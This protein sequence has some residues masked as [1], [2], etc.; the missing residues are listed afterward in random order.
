VGPPEVIKKSTTLNIGKTFL[1][2]IPQV[3][4]GP[5]IATWQGL[6]TFMGKNHQLW[7]MP[8]G[9]DLQSACVTVTL[10]E[11]GTFFD[12]ESLGLVENLTNIWDGQLGPLLKI[13]KTAGDD[14][15][16]NPWL[17]IMAC[18]TPKAIARLFSEEMAGGGLASRIVWLYGDKP[19]RSVAYPS[20]QRK[21]EHIAALSERLRNGLL[22]AADYCGPFKLTD[23]AYAWGERWYEQ[24]RTRR[25][26]LAG[27]T[28][29]DF[30]VRRQTHLH[31]I[32]MVLS[33][34]R[35]KFPVIDVAEMEEA[36]SKLDLLESYAAHVFGFVGTSA[37]SRTTQAIIEFVTRQGATPVHRLFRSE[38]YR[39]ISLKEFNAALAAA[40]ATGLV[41]VEDNTVRGV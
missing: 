25:D 30:Y 41:V 5:D 34:A 16:N 4:F 10:S 11:F 20:R 7:S 24:Y 21:P 3:M 40:Q 29:G 36:N 18:T 28:A 19:G 1:R 12:P 9:E 27:T 8:D 6:I 2:D 32:A 39:K 22:R 17:N 23:A 31:K 38:F 13:T 14:E 35:A 15:V 33:A 26:A 37:A